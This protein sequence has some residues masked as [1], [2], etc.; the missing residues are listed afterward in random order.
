[1]PSTIVA[2]PPIWLSVLL[3]EDIPGIILVTDCTIDRQPSPWHPCFA[4]CATS[5]VNSTWLTAPVLFVATAAD[6]RHSFADGRCGVGLTAP[7]TL[8]ASCAVSNAHGS[9]LGWF[10]VAGAEPGLALG[11]A[12]GLE[13]DEGAGLVAA[14]AAL[15]PCMAT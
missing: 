4:S 14:S 10:P 13:D 2:V 7:T 1:M 8:A 3:N 11:V 12:D 9:T 15:P 5:A 6:H